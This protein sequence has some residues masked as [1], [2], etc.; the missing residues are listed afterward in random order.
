MEAAVIDR[1]AEEI[2]KVDLSDHILAWDKKQGGFP[3]TP[4]QRICQ[5]HPPHGRLQMHANGASLI[6]AH[7]RPVPCG[8]QE[9]VSR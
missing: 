1:V 9:P 4:E 8:Y 3:P 5:L 7:A 2:G 6:C